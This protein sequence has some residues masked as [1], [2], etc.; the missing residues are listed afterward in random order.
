MTS[1]KNSTSTTPRSPETRPDTSTSEMLTPSEVAS[2]R[3]AAK[4]GIAYARREFK[5]RREAAISGS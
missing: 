4:E 2:L 5:R 3:Q 1:E